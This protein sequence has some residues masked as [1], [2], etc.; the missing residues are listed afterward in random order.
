ME[1]IYRLENPIQYYAWG[2]HTAIAALQRRSTPTEDP[3]AELWMG[4]H[5]KAPS[6]VLMGEEKHSLLALMQYESTKILGEDVDRRFTGRLPFLLKVLAAEKPLSIQAHPNLEQARTGYAR[7]NE[8]GI[9]VDAWDRSY[10]DDNHK[11]ELICA[12]T[13]FWALRGF[14]AYPSILFWMERL[15]IDAL[16]EERKAFAASPDEE[17]LKA[18]YTALLTLPQ[19]RKE[20]ALQEALRSAERLVGEEGE[21]GDIGRWILR[22]AADYPGDI[23]I[24]SPALLHVVC[25]QPGQAMYLP[26]GEL[27]AYL[28]GTG[29]EIMA[30]SDNVLRG[31]LTV[32]H[33]DVPE[34]LQ[35]LRF[36]PTNIEVLQPH[37]TA[38]SIEA[39]YHTPNEEFVLSVLE[40]RDG[41]RFH[42]P[43]LRS[44]EILLCLQGRAEIKAHGQSEIR[45]QQGDAILIPADAPAYQVTGQAT[46]YKATTPLS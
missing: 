37:K 20:K 1:H 3:E 14:R 11:P 25:L 5:P 12:M 15:Q 4:A 33:I 38:N 35:V 6:Q 46:L 18:F 43:A 44:A 17:G 32:K 29:I 26:D 24:L 7:E 36:T 39:I 13:P 19:E 2:S 28:E 23:G 40:L 45:L 21:A 31:G 42:S 34:L 27:H 16:L 30:N 9:P 22:L 41:A 8:L 10:R